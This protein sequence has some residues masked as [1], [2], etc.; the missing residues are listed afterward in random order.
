MFPKFKFA[1][2]KWLLGNQREYM[3]TGEINRNHEVNIVGVRTLT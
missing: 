1:L 2:R 3:E